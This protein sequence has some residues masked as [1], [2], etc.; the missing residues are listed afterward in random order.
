MY[1]KKTLLAKCQLNWMTIQKLHQLIP[2]IVALFYV[3]RMQYLHVYMHL[4]G[5]S[6]TLFSAI[7]IDLGSNWICKLLGLSLSRWRISIISL[8]VRLCTVTRFIIKISYNKNYMALLLVKNTGQRTKVKNNT[9]W[10]RIR[11]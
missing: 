1:V 2:S 11:S 10:T 9:D 4:R 5:S 6:T 8:G 7:L 3:Y